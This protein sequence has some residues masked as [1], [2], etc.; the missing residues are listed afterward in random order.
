MRSNISR[1]ALLLLSAVLLVGCESYQ[2]TAP[3][4]NK[5]ANIPLPGLA[6]RW[7]SRSES[8]N[9]YQARWVP[10]VRGYDVNLSHSGQ[11][12][13]RLLVTFAKMGNA[14]VA[15]VTTWPDSNNTF[16][17]PVHM[18]FPVEFSGRNLTIYYVSDDAFKA[19]IRK[20]HLR[21]CKIKYSDTDIRNLINEDSS[22]K[23][24]AA[25]QYALSLDKKSGELVY[26]RLSKRAR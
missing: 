19:A 18:A 11:K 9:S 26:D 14:T 17:L 7:V 22:A 5:N 10:E 6:G 4:W 16:V 1:F 8:H 2:S 12:P 24:T 13:L 3:F 20:Y 15:D 23:L 21:I 25:L